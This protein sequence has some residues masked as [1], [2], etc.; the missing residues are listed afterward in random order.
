MRR[1]WILVFVAAISA[2]P[3]SSLEQFLRNFVGNKPTQYAMALLDLNDDGVPEAIVYLTSQGWCGSGGCTVL[4]LTQNAGA[5]KLV[6]KYRSC[7]HR[8]AF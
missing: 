8:S 4:I 1:C 6:T 5:W 2:Q 7:G 3:Q